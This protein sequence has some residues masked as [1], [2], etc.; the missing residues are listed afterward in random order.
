MTQGTSQ[1]RFT[2]IRSNLKAFAVVAALAAACGG[3]GSPQGTPAGASA[4]DGAAASPGSGTSPAPTSAS[5][6]ACLGAD[7]LASLGK[8]SV[9]VGFMGDDAVSSQA[10]WDF[11]YQYL[12]SGVAPAD[13]TCQTG[14]DWWGCWQDPR[15]APGQFVTDQLTT[16]AANGQ[17]PMFTYYVMLRASGAGEGAGEVAAANDAAFMTR[18][19]ADWRFFLGKVGSRT[20][21]LHV[22]PDFWGF[23]QKVNANPH[24]IPAAV[25]S[26]APECAGYEDSIAGLGRCMIHMARVHAP[27]ARIGLQASGWATSI[28]VLMNASASLDV[29][30]EARKV[31]AFLSGCGATEADYTVVE[32]SDRDAGWYQSQGRQTWW[33]A[34]NA[35]VP[36]FHQALSWAKTL[37]ESIGKPLLWWQIPVGNMEQVNSD[38]HWKDNRVQYFFDHPGEFAAAHGIGIAFGAGM[39]GQTTPSTDGRYLAQRAASYLAAGGEAF[40]ATK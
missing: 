26:A 17:I 37:A 34:T 27:N 33:D 8:K 16:A 25:S 1:G 12:A 19:L 28:D 10:R 13:G 32:M 36:S 18:Y 14:T 40:C 6:G 5:G 15:I 7:L 9:L 20:A 24:A 35:T 31:A 30:G 2:E 21:L 23:A 38:L 22:E 29:A 11:H 3:P 39:T 4:G